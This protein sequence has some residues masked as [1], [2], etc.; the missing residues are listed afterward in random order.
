MDK[1]PDGEG[2][3]KDVF[4][5][6]IC[7]GML[8]A[9]L[10]IGYGVYQAY[11]DMGIEIILFPVGAILIWVLGHLVRGLDDNN[12]RQCRGCNYYYGN[13]FSEWKHKRGCLPWLTKYR[14]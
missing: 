4:T 10:A 1:T 5:G 14:V 2:V 13:M 9:I 11:L 8:V 12:Q 7:L 6:L 3:C